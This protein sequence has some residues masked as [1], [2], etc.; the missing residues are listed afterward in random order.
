MVSQERAED[1]EASEPAGETETVRV[2]HELMEFPVL[3]RR[4]VPPGPRTVI[5][6]QRQA[7]IIE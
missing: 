5:N 4:D 7:R 1:R 3:G 2:T 6:M